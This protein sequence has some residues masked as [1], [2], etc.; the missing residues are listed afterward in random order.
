M[1]EWYV[2]SREMKLKRQMGKT[3]EY[4]KGLVDSQYPLSINALMHTGAFGKCDGVF[5]YI[6]RMIK[7]QGICC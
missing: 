3:S 6:T 1:T 7:H 4:Y 5:S 2:M